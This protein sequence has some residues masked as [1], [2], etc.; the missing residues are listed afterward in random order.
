VRRP[1]EAALVAGAVKPVVAE[2]VAEEEQY[3]RPPLETDR[4]NGEAMQPGEE[5]VLESFGEQIY[6][7]VAQAHADARRCILQS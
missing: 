3:P 4:E 1:E 2:L 6:K 5:A 7:H